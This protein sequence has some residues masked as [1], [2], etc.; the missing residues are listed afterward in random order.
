MNDT[1]FIKNVLDD[2]TIVIETGNRLDNN[3]AHEMVETIVSIQIQGTKNI[4]IDMQKL[5]FISSAG[6]GSVLGTVETSREMG[7]DITLCNASS[8]IMQV[9][10]ILDLVDYLTIK[11]NMTDA[12]QPGA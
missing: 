11:A 4:I 6:V 2:D 1:T 7:G 8:A 5:E 10:E 9:L 12:I 3:N